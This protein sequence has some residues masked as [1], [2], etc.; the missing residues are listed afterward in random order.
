MVSPARNGGEPP[1]VEAMVVAFP[2]AYEVR[3]RGTLPP[4]L[5]SAFRPLESRSEANGTVTVLAGMIRDQAELT[6]I[7]NTLDS[8]GLRLL[9][10]RP[11]RAV[12]REG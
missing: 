9:E 5:R 10:V 6:G 2:Q 8:L 7:L 3:V 4:S 1:P 12:T 11:A